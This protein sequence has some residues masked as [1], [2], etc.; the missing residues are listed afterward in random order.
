MSDKATRQPIKIGAIAVEGFMMPDGSYR[1]SQTSAAAA[2]G[3]DEINARR[4]LDSTGIK[5]LLGKGY[6]PDTIEVESTEQARGQTRINALP[7]E[8]VTAFWVWQCFRG[9]KQAIALVMGLATETLERRFDA[10]F[11]VS[12]S[13]AD[14]NQRLSDRLQQLEASLEQLGA[15]YAEPDTL[16]EHIARLEQQ[17]RDNG[18]Q[19]W[20]LPLD[21]AAG[22]K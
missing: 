16:R 12:R 6:T 13:E 18:L 22:D 9:N 4:F 21:D 10:A 3:K 1:M 17:L 20:E 5:T 14:Y 2:V 7:L 19:P 15:A 8:V 11:G